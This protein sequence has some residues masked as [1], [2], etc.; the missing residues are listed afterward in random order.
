[1]GGAA[2]DPGRP[3]PRRWPIS[4]RR[5]GKIQ[6]WPSA[7]FSLAPPHPLLLLQPHVLVRRREVEQRIQPDRRFLDPRPHAMQRG[8]LEDRP[9]HHTPLH[10]PPR[11][12]GERLTP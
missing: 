2:R 10:H 12:K 6:W 9:R 7:R 3:R 11:P 1:E 4:E 5:A 8:W